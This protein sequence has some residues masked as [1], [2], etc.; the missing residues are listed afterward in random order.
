MKKKRKNFI[1]HQ[2]EKGC[3]YILLC[4]QAVSMDGQARE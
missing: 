1:R 3:V 2:L 4:L